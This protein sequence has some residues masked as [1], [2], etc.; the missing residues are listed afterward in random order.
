MAVATLLH[1]SMVSM[2]SRC[3]SANFARARRSTSLELRV[4][5]PLRVAERLVEI[6][7]QA[8]PRGQRRDLLGAG[9]RRDQVGFEDLDAVEARLGAG[10]Q[11][12]GQRAAEADGGDGGAHRLIHRR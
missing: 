1:T 11:L 3:I 8:E 9:R 12:V 4:G 2:P 6:Q 7:R 5:D 10:V